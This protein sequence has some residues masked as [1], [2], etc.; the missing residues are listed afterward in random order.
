MK[1]NNHVTRWTKFPVHYADPSYD[2]E[3]GS[4]VVALCR[5]SSRP[6]PI[7]R[8]EGNW[9]V[10]VQTSYED[11]VTCKNCLRKLKR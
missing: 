11:S 10:S 9:I 7:S 1:K 3:Y 2:C 8:R 5:G 6:T 4:S